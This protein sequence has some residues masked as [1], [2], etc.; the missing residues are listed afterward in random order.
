MKSA[1]G[2]LAFEAKPSEKDWAHR[3]VGGD[4]TYSA[5]IN[6]ASLPLCQ[7]EHDSVPED[8]QKR[9]VRTSRMPQFFK[10]YCL[11]ADWEGFQAGSEL[12]AYGTC[13]IDNRKVDVWVKV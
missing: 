9:L 3:I 4:S 8:L 11:T 12:V 13:G 10:R 2:T 1:Q 7:H 5:Y 6:P